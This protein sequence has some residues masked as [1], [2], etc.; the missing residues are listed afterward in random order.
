MLL[1]LSC[2]GKAKRPK[3]RIF[4]CGFDC[5][6]QALL[7]LQDKLELPTQVLNLRWQV[8]TRSKAPISQIYLM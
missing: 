4:R 8:L 2:R 1:N 3:E 7:N 6:R 5:M